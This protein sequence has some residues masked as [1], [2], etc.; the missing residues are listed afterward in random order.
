MRDPEVKKRLLSCV[1][2]V[3]ELRPRELPIR[4][5]CLVLGKSNSMLGKD[6][7]TVLAGFCPVVTSLLLP[8][9][10]LDH[11]IDELD[12]YSQKWIF[13]SKRNHEHHQFNSK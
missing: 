12:A 2:R 11:K 7:F 8:S 6:W 10:K 9:A 4:E 13:G 1:A 5:L 3:L